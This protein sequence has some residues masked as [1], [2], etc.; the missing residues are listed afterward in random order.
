MPDTLGHSSVVP[1]LLKTLEKRLSRCCP[2]PLNRDAHDLAQAFI[3]VGHRAVVHEYQLS[4]WNGDLPCRYPV[5]RGC[6]LINRLQPEHSAITGVSDVD[7]RE[8]LASY[9]VRNSLRVQLPPT[10]FGWIECRSVASA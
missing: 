3:H 5:L 1:P 10:D 6:I 9:R 8:S 7:D 2:F 4:D